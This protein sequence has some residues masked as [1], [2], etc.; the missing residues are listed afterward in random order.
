MDQAPTRPSFT[1]CGRIRASTA[2]RSMRL[3]FRARPT[4]AR[5]GALPSESTRPRGIRHSHPWLRS[6]LRTPSG[7]QHRGCP[8]GPE[9]PDGV[10]NVPRHSLREPCRLLRRARRP[11]RFGVLWPGPGRRPDVQ[12]GIRRL[13]NLRG[14]L[15]HALHALPQADCNRR[16]A[17][18][19]CVGRQVTRSPTTAMTNI[20]NEQLL[21]ALLTRSDPSQAQDEDASVNRTR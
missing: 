14:I 12:A 2:A 15:K 3:P 19:I 11:R 9:C 4:A 6:T 21:G 7:L 10:H 5:P 18:S 20:A 13:S 16:A 1:S 17:R 8:P